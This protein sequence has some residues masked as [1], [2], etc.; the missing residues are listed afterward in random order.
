M[1]EGKWRVQVETRKDEMIGSGKGKEKNKRRKI[2]SV[3]GMEI[4]YGWK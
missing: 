2:W 3:I 1:E 4:G